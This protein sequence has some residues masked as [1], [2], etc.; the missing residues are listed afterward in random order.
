MPFDPYKYVGEE[1]PATEE[2]SPG[3]YAGKRDEIV[4]NRAQRA[5]ELRA[6]P[7]QLMAKMERDSAQ[8]L[9][10]G[11]ENLTPKERGELM[12]LQ[13]PAKALKS[14]LGI[15]WREGLTE[16]TARIATPMAGQRVGEATRLPGGRQIGGFAGGV[17]GE[18][19]ATGGDASAG[20]LLQAGIQGAT[21][22]R[23][24]AGA[25]VSEVA[26]EAKRLAAIN[27]SASAAQQIVD[28][29]SIDP[30]KLGAQAIA[31][32]AGA[33]AGRALDSG[34]TARKAAI[35]QADNAVVNS[36]IARAK[37]RGY[38][39]LPEAARPDRFE[40]AT[41]S[42]VR[43]DIGLPPTAPLSEETFSR[44]FKKL[45]DV[46]DEAAKIS[47]VAE[48]NLAGMKSARLE[49]KKL[50]KKYNQESERLGQ[51]N[52]ELLAAA[53]EY[54]ALADVFENDLINEATAAGKKKIAQ[55]L[56]ETRPLLAKTYLAERSVNFSRGVADAKVYGQA[57][58]NG[59]KLTG[60]ARTIADAFNANLQKEQAVGSLLSR[61]FTIGKIAKRAVELSDVGQAY[62]A[63]GPAYVQYP[64]ISADIA[65]L[66]AM[67]Q[68]RNLE[69]DKTQSVINFLKMMPSESGKP[70]LA[71]SLYPGV[72]QQPRQ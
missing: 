41:N 54:D 72:S 67:Q 39:V 19:I 23:S 7:A 16:Q 51:S 66:A 31:G 18:Y 26:N 20:Q 8:L 48:A 11:W 13:V 15:D 6:M 9:S 58:E 70:A 63:A 59:F 37:E 49:A 30:V 40:V 25:G 14:I 34:A 1:A 21:S 10:K 27:T 32:G 2:F 50:W 52:P 57:L 45:W 28:E 55:K 62:I 68:G 33:I 17:A 22:G 65:R 3:K 36:V 56:I 61:A 69:G 43:A 5:A 42:L 60:D 44:H 64:D 71:N 53:K 46:Y 35:E 29:A 4:A 12:A 47:P 24:M 38:K